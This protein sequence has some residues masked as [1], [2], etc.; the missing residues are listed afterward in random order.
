[1]LQDNARY[2][3]QEATRLGSKQLDA[4]GDRNAADAVQVKG[5][6]WG[7]ARKTMREDQAKKATQQSW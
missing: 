2:L 1:M 3:K 7:R 5:A 6:D 4:Y